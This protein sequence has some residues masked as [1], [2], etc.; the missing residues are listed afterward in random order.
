MLNRGHASAPS[1]ALGR[2]PSRILR[3]IRFSMDCTHLKCTWM[4]KKETEQYQR[5]KTRY[6]KERKK[7]KEDEEEAREKEEDEEE[8]ENG[9]DV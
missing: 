8:E 7:K 9:N 2:M 6:S 5:V 4:K 1:L 3:G